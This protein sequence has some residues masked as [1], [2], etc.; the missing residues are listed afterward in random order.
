MSVKLPRKPRRDPT[1]TF[2]VSKNARRQRRLFGNCYF[3][4]TES[5]TA[6]KLRSARSFAERATFSTS[7][8]LISRDDQGRKSAI[9]VTRAPFETYRGDPA[10]PDCA[11]VTR[12]IELRNRVTGKCLDGA[13]CITLTYPALRVPLFRFP[14]LGNRRLP[15]KQRDAARCAISRQL[16]RVLYG[17]LVHLSQPKSPFVMQR[18]K[19]QP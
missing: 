2:A 17:R 19:E 16:F 1:Q 18:A 8:S 4:A 15:G 11:I 5:E 9:L 14:S 10:I 13:A 12:G 6:C 3:F 7:L